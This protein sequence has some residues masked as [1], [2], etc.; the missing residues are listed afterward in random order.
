MSKRKQAVRSGASA[1]RAPRRA[2]WVIGVCAAVVVVAIVVLKRPPGASPPVGS[3]AAST[4]ANVTS[5]AEQIP[6]ERL[7]GRWQRTEGEYVLEFRNAAASGRIEAGYFNPKS[8]HVSR[9]EWRR[10]NDA[11]YAFVELRDENYPGATYKL[12]YIPGA[13]QL[14]GEYFQPL[15][16]QTFEVF[17]VRL[18]K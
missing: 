18:P 9:A 10:D 6:L 14:A 11:L 3:P 2:W 12:R 1:V 17:F 4:N 13:D 15:L 5:A 8:I 16:G 7:T